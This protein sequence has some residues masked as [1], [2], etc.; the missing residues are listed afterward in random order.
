MTFLSRIFLLTAVSTV[1]FLTSYCQPGQSLKEIAVDE[2]TLSIE[3]PQ[4][5]LRVG[6]TL[7]TPFVVKDG[8]DVDGL[9]IR[10]WQHVATDLDLNYEYRTYT[11]IDSLKNAVKTGD[12]D[13][14]INPIIV[15]AM[16]YSEMEF[17]QPVLISNLAIAVRKEETSL[18]RELVSKIFT[19]EF[20]TGLVAMGFIILLFG[21]LAWLFER[22]S[23]SKQFPN[24]PRG[25][26]DSFWWSAVTMTTVGYGDKAPKTIGGR[27]IA[28]AW[29]FTAVIIVASYTATI[30]S[31]LTLDK[32]SLDIT[33]LEDLRSARILADGKSQ[34]KAYLRRH[35]V[36]SLEADDPQKA[37]DLVVQKEADAFVA[38]EVLL[39][40]L[41]DKGQY[42]KDLVIAPGKFMKQYYAFAMV[43][44]SEFEKPINMA[45]MKTL[46]SKEWMLETAQYLDE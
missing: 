28:V 40:Y 16:D 5:K 46:G 27:L 1:L 23:N 36:N 19:W 32:L 42:S 10:L 29:M 9:S 37:L 11:D 43:S 41:F 38:D 7:E 8:S 14:A 13:V 22:K 30:S 24:T 26:W 33:S 45:L 12:I 44:G 15:S 31:S 6:Y 4:K 20:L 34:V 25:L 18:L 39:R 21:F 3:V 2:D 35:G 17:S